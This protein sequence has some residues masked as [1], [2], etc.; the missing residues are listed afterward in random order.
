VVTFGS[1]VD[2]P[3]PWP[4]QQ[5]DFTESEKEARADA[6]FASRQKKAREERAAC[7]NLWRGPGGGA[8]GGPIGGTGGSIAGLGVW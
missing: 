1:L 2:E 8:M 4:A 3:A 5:H 7:H 6:R